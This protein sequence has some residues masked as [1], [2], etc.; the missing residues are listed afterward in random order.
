MNRWAATKTLPWFLLSALLAVGCGRTPL[1]PPSPSC[2]V[3]VTP[4]L[5]DFGEVLPG[6]TATGSVRIDNRGGAAC[7]LSGIAIA[8]DS[9]KGFAIEPATP[10]SVAVDADSSALVGLVFRTESASAPLQRTGRL[11]FSVEETTPEGWSMA[12]PLTAR[13][14]SE[15]VLEISPSAVD[16]GRV[17]LGRSDSRVVLMSNQGTGRCEIRDI[18]LATGS[19]PQFH[20]F[21]GEATL[22]PGE[23]MPVVGVTFHATDASRPRHRTANLTF[24]TTDPKQAKAVVPLSADIDVGC[25]LTWT[26]A[27]L[28]FGLVILNNRVSGNVVLGNE[29]TDTCL[30]SG[31]GIAAGSDPNFTLDGA[32][33]LSVAPGASATVRVLFDGFDSAPPHAKTGTLVMQS[34]GLR[35]PEVRIPLAAYVS[36]V[37]IE[38]SRWVYT[39]DT[40]ARLSR[41]DPA[42]RTFTDIGRLACPSS[43]S[44]NSMA[45]DQDAVAWVGYSDGNLF[46][47]DTGTGKCEATS[48]VPNQHGINVFGMGFV[49]D[50]ATG[51]DTLYIAG[52]PNYSGI[53]ETRLATVSFPSLVVTEIGTVE[54]GDAELTGTGDGELW[55]F[56]PD[57]RSTGLVKQSV[58]VRIDPSSGK[59]LEAHSYSSLSTSTSSAVSWAVK[60]WGGSFWIFLNDS[61]YEVSRATPDKIDPVLTNTRRRIVGAG[62]STCA[63]V[64]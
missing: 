39:V 6:Q 4:L 46:R 54:A 57:R 34:S 43:S 22:E 14:R 23:T 62:V 60:F 44:P 27:K 8:A 21:Q 15:C 19:D 28:D 47:V 7:R 32:R 42:N 55:G 58:L 56:V 36:T 29:G 50:P 26:P 41:F 31:I 33:A 49:F 3:E 30:V 63:P 12:V 20:L 45:V 18:R 13:I 59:T 38:A 51:V 64:Q 10:T 1:L 2:L 52:G 37:C 5:V 17:R 25:E 61:I 48:F 53:T 11:V 40:D 35:D 9:D 24:V 16:F